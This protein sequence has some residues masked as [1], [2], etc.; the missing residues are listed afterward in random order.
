MNR[1]D[2]AIV[3]AGPAGSSLAIQLAQQGQRVLLLEK[4]TFPREKTC[5]D[6]VSAKGLTLLERLGCFKPLKETRYVP[7]RQARTALNGKWLSRGGIPYR[8]DMFPY[9]HA[10][11]RRV[12]DEIMFRRAQ[13][14]G[15]HTVENCKVTGI[16]HETDGISISGEQSNKLVKFNAHLVVGADG[17]HSVVAREVDQEMSDARYMEYALRAY[18]YGLAIDESVILFEE[19]FFPGF[20]WVFPVT[21][22]LANV[23]VGLVAE[24]AK[25]FGLHLNK[26]FDRLV[27]RLK[28][29]AVE[30]GWRI[31]IG[32]PVGWPIKTYGGAGYNFFE[33]GLLIGEAGCFVDPMNGEGIPLAMQSAELAAKTISSAFDRGDFGRETLSEYGRQWRSMFDPD[34]RIS[35]LLVSTIRNRHLLKLWIDG[36]KLICRTAESDPDY[37]WTMGG[38]LAGTVGIRDSLEPDML[39]KAFIEAIRSSTELP[40]SPWAHLSSLGRTI[41]L[42]LWELSTLAELA[43]DSKWVLNWWKEIAQKQALVLR[44]GREYARAY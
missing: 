33:R 20:G 24:S 17:A 37:A 3:G 10:V 25:K 16:T 23:G 12:L 1:Y 31:E 26:F 36:L 29:W 43:Q 4:N 5:G 21:D 38:I 8:P 15:A 41:E 11:P 28:D 35:D 40:S 42:A 7:I 13:N 39:L 18:C 44:L 14:V 2:V 34:L 6:L 30:E 19:D 9:A 27:H 22:G 32:K